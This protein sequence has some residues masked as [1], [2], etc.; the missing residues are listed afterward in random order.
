MEKAEI[1]NE[2]KRAVKDFEEYFATADYTEIP[3]GLSIL[4]EILDNCSKAEF[5]TK[6]RVCKRDGEKSRKVT[7]VSHETSEERQE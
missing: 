6:P 5:K 7:N 1:L 2:V 4:F 3:L